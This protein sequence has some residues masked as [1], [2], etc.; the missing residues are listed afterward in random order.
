MVLRL[1]VP[2]ASGRWPASAN[3]KYCSRRH[4]RVCWR[5]RVPQPQGGAKRVAP[6][7]S[8][9]PQDGHVLRSLAVV[10]FALWR[11]RARG[12][13]LNATCTCKRESQLEG[14]AQPTLSPP[15][16]DTGTH[17]PP[18]APTLRTAAAAL[19]SPLTACKCE[20]TSPDSERHPIH[21]FPHPAR[22]LPT[23]TQ[24]PPPS[25][26]SIDRHVC[27]LRLAHSDGRRTRVK[28]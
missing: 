26:S 7:L 17:A 19:S 16:M 2:S 11:L 27:I 13:T 18:N 21:L 4:V 6:D 1:T 25:L 22:A 28:R 3:H 12:Y 24:H 10:E 23:L 8:R 15:P 5:C 20:P 14:V 9:L